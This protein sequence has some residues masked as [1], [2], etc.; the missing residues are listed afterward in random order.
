MLSPR[1]IVQ[2]SGMFGLT[3]RQPRVVECIV[4][5]P[6]GNA[7]SGLSM[8]Y[9]ARVIDSTPPATMIEASP[10]AIVRAAPMTA[11]RLEPQSR[12]T[13]EPGTDG[14]SPASSDAIRAT[15]RL[16]SPAWFAAPKYTSPIRAGSSDV[17]RS[18]SALITTAARSS[19]RTLANAP[20]NLPTGVRTASTMNTS[21]PCTLP[22]EAC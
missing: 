21:R 5:L 7:R 13:V 20:P 17:V 4:A 19:G 18:S 22:P 1:L 11:S 16:S 9:G 6:A 2:S 3:I 10:T 14:G 12:L 8:T 15:L